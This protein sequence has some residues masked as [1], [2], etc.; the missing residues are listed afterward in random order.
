MGAYEAKVN[1]E[2]W[3]NVASQIGVSTAA[4]ATSAGMSLLTKAIIGISAAS[5]ITTA[6]VIFTRS[7]EPSEK[8]SIE[9]TQES[10]EIAQNA[11]NANVVL[12]STAPKQNV[13]ATSTE[14]PEQSTARQAMELGNET[15]TASGTI[16]SNQGN[17]GTSQGIGEQN[18]SIKP[19]NTAPNAAEG[20][21]DPIAVGNQ[22]LTTPTPTLHTEDEP[23]A[24]IQTAP[25]PVEEEEIFTIEL[26]NVITPNGDRANDYL[27]LEVEDVKSFYVKIVDQEGNMVF[28]S[29][30]PKF[31]W[32]ATNMYTGLPVTKGIHMY[33]VI[34]EN[35]DGKIFKDDQYL[36]VITD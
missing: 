9:A 26:P 1:P 21:T 16:V 36:M 32:D 28:E 10:K 18:P 27:S 31:Q 22:M 6:A 15:P 35:E 34:V 23:T 29:N 17:I 20:V 14:V 8:A 2:L 33:F 3:T 24:P 5:V 4:S 19:S 7:E 25:T 12:E 30:D 13:A 11:Q